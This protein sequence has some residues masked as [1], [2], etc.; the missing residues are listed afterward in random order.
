MKKSELVKRINKEIG[1]TAHDASETINYIFDAIAA[2][3]KA[4]GSYNQDCFGTFKIVERAARIGRNPTT[5]ER[6]SIPKKKAV[7][8]IISGSLKKDIN[9]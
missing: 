3:L 5:G 7:K 1:I 4:G 6:I 2:E 9:K 8:F